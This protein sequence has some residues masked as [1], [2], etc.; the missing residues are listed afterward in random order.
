MGSMKDLARSHPA[1]ATEPGRSPP[2]WAGQKSGPKKSFSGFANTAGNSWKP[3]K[4]SFE[5][6][7]SDQ[8]SRNNRTMQPIPSMMLQHQTTKI[9]YIRL[10]QLI[11]ELPGA[12]L[13]E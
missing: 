10:A 12:V 13:E 6:R 2:S 4:K 5:S 3:K 11:A 9:V 8:L 7:P 1:P